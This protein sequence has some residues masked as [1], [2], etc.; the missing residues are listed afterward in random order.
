M[1]EKAERVDHLPAA[2]LHIRAIG[3]QIAAEREDQREHMLW[4]G[5]E[6]VV[7]DVAD[8]YPP[9]LASRL[10]DDVGSGRRHGYEFKIGKTG[11][12]VG[13][14]RDLVGDRYGRVLK[15]IYHLIGGRRI[16]C[17]EF[18]RKTWRAQLGADGGAVEKDD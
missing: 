14:D 6:G 11:Q 12:G 17:T 7:A 8:R 10:I 18:M 9:R 3:D 13:A 1:I 4:N 2:T 16:I 5:I 15:P